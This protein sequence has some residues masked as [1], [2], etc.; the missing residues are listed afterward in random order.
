MRLMENKKNKIVEN[1][2]ILTLSYFQS[3]A[4]QTWQT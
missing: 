1:V 4:F 3:I 2:K